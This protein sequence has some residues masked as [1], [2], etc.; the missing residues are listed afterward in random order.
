[1]SLSDLASLGSFVSGVAVI[2][3]LVFLFFQMRQMTE[4][5]RQAERNQRSLINQNVASR[6]H[7]INVLGQQVAVPFGKTYAGTTDFT[8][9]EII[10][11]NLFLRA[12]LGQMQ[13]VYVQNKAG[14]IEQDT[15]EY[16]EAGVR[17]L[18]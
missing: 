7:E 17:T 1:M 5:V 15:Y 4:Q 9:P 18:L 11:L 12:A 2:A 8:A 3:S 10:T 16:V 6:D 13:D 14:L